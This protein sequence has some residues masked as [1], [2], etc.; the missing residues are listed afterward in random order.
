MDRE[1]LLQNPLPIDRV[2]AR[3][4]RASKPE[5]LWRPM[6]GLVALGAMWAGYVL[7]ILWGWFVVPTF[8]LPPLAL[9]PAIGLALVAGYLTHQ[10]TPKAAKPEDDGKWDETVRAT[11]HMLL[12]PASTLLI[13][14]VVKQWM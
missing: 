8:A 1:K 13:G 14:W 3:V 10:Y 12:R 4:V 7:M 5:H 6:L 11:A 9:A 2:A